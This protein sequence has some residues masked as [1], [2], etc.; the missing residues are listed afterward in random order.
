MYLDFAELQALSRKTM[1]MGDWLTKLDDFMRISERDI[2]SHS[3]KVSHQEA[4]EKA[5]EEYSKY[6][7]QINAL[8]PV[9]KHFFEAVREIKNLGAERRMQIILSKKLLNRK[10]AVSILTGPSLFPCYIQT[11]TRKRKAITRD[12]KYLRRN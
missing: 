5:R 6:R 11:C 2:L 10:T 1:H 3:G 9:E 8:S 4:L 7:E 12:T